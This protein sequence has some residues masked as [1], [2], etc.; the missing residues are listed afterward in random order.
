MKNFCPVPFKEIYFEEALGGR[1]ASCC[2]MDK[3]KTTKNIFNKDFFKTDE[4]LQNIRQEFLLDR[5][6]KECHRCWEI[7]DR[8]MDSYRKWFGLTQYNE[9]ATIDLNLIDIR[10]SNKCNLQCKMCGAEFSNQIAKNMKQNSHLGFNISDKLLNPENDKQ[11]L[12]D[13]LQVI[14]NEPTVKKIKLAGGE[15]FIMDEV[16]YFLQRLIDAGKNDIDLFIIS[17]MTT[18]NSKLLNVLKKFPK[19]EIS[20]SIDGVG[21]W[22]EY[23]RFPAKWKTIERN[24]KRLTEVSEIKSTLTPCISQLNLHGIPEFLDWASTTNTK[25]IAHNDV[26]DP[27][28]LSYELIPLKYRKGLKDKIYKSLKKCNRISQSWY[29]FVDQ[30]ESTERTITQIEQNKLTFYVKLWD[31]NNTIKYVDF[32]PWGK[33]LL[34]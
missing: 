14:C 19:N 33:E 30:V 9:N 1:Y 6:P 22:I 28:Y 5:R 23:Q 27:S 12:E 7:E 18:I 32:C 25:W 3:N 29:K 17:N 11:I 13:A 4:H 20:C 21:K 24:F 2:Q 16:L 31:S 8:G 10:L 26:I 15:P 34:S